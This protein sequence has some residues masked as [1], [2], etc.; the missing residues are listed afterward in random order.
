MEATTEALVGLVRTR[1]QAG[2]LRQSRWN[3]YEDRPRAAVPGPQ[4]NGGGRMMDSM[5][6]A[7]APR[8]D[9][10]DRDDNSWWSA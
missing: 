7:T 8:T 2:E 1:R 5:A 9:A 3:A 6:R 10:P 4:C